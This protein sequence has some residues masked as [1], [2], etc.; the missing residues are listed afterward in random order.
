MLTRTHTPSAHPRSSGPL[1]L[2]PKSILLISHVQEAHGNDAV[3]FDPSGGYSLSDAVLPVEGDCR[4]NL[5]GIKFEEGV[6]SAHIL[7]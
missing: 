7:V 6:F 1:K 2:T 5:S 4:C 3:T